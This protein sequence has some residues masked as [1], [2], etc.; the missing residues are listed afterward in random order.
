MTYEAQSPRSAK[1][2]L[3]CIDFYDIEECLKF[4]SSAVHESDGCFLDD[5]RMILN[6]LATASQINRDML[7]RELDLLPSTT[8]CAYDLSVDLGTP[9]PPNAETILSREDALVSLKRVLPACVWFK[10]LVKAYWKHYNL[11]SDLGSFEWTLDDLLR[12][13]RLARVPQYFIDDIIDCPFAEEFL[14][15]LAA[16]RYIADAYHP[17]LVVYLL[18]GKCQDWAVEERRREEMERY[19]RNSHSFWY[20]MHQQHFYDGNGPDHFDH[21]PCPPPHPHPHFPQRNEMQHQPRLPFKHHP[22][23]SPHGSRRNGFDR[24][25]T[26]LASP[27]LG[28]SSDGLP[29]HDDKEDPQVPLIRNADSCVPWGQTTPWSPNSPLQA[30]PAPPPRADALPASYAHTPQAHFT[31]TVEFDPLTSYNKNGSCEAPSGSPVACESPLGPSEVMMQREHQ[32]LVEFNT[33]HAHSDRS[34]GSQMRPASNALHHRDSLSSSP[35]SDQ[36]LSS[37]P[38]NRSNPS[39]DDN[40]HTSAMDLDAVDVEFSANGSS[41]PKTFPPGCDMRPEERCRLQDL[42]EEMEEMEEADDSDYEMKMTQDEASSTS[43]SVL[44]TDESEERKRQPTRLQGLDS[45]RSDSYEYDAAL[46]PI[47]RLPDASHFHNLQKFIDGRPTD[48]G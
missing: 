45:S 8:Q 39:L 31:S 14:Y 4:L 3:S 20:G 41:S 43:S 10:R 23:R 1:P 30:A 28:R 34:S 37:S 19:R 22:K 29:L 2:T 5:K 47:H 42:C 24:N 12:W 17:K 7:R 44:S 38:S 6:D 25:T 40:D 16:M 26:I 13:A 15:N 48:G 36:T 11:P 35:L 18:R 33:S 21:H 32:P 27:L 9:T 46:R